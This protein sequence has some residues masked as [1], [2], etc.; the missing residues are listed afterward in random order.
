MTR[1]R[2]RALAGIPHTRQQDAHHHTALT[3]AE[4][5]GARR[6]GR[7]PS[8]LSPQPSAR[9]GTVRGGAGRG[10]AR[11]GSARFGSA[12]P[13]SAR[14]GPAPRPRLFWFS[15]PQRH[16]RERRRRLA[17]SRPPPRPISGRDWL[18][19]WGGFGP[20]G[21]EGRGGGRDHVGRGERDGAIRA[22]RGDA[23]GRCG[24][25]LHPYSPTPLQP[26]TLQPYTPTAFTQP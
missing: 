1:F 5:P 23:A 21:R 3:S 2:Y 6:A 10:W 8:A 26:Y 20:L 7:L 11:L 4:P 12:R 25:C 19:R 15:S 24:L 9:S 17:G 14:P 18:G 22:G 16:G 13:R